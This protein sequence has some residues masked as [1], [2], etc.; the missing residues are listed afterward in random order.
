LHLSSKIILHWDVRDGDS[1]MKHLSQVGGR[2][3]F[4]FLD[5]LNPAPWY[6]CIWKSPVRHFAAT[7]SFSTE[8]FFNPLKKKKRKPKSYPHLLY[9]HPERN[10][11]PWNG[12]LKN[13]FRN[14]LSGSPAWG[15]NQ[16][17]VMYWM[18]IG[19]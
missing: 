11:L 14:F 2:W 15:E 16:K 7:H 6:P 17:C 1:W 9:S 5:F 10:L 18:F 3:V 4:W 12:N 13:K 8:T 19:S